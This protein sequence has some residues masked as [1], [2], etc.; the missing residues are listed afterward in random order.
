M[1]FKYNKFR[2]QKQALEG[3]DEQTKNNSILLAF[4]AEVNKGQKLFC[5]FPITEI[6]KVEQILKNNYHCYEWL[7]PNRQLKPFFDCEMEGEEFTI[8]ESAIRIRV[9]INFVCREMNTIFGSSIT[10]KDIIVLNS[11]RQGK[12]SYHLVINNHI[13]FANMEEHRIFIHWL[14]TKFLSPQEN[15]IEERQLLTWSRTTKGEIF[16]TLKI[17]DLAV[18]SNEQKIR[19]IN[20][21][22]MG[23]AYLLKNET[24]GDLKQSLIGLY[25]GVGDRQLLNV[26]GLEIEVSHKKTMNKNNKKTQTKTTA[27]NDS[28]TTTGKTIMIQRGLSYNELEK[29]ENYQQY[30]FLIP[31]TAQ[32][33]DFFMKMRF[34]IAQAGGKKEEFEEWARLSP[35]YNKNDQE[36]K[37][38]STIQ[39]EY[40]GL[41]F[42]KKYAKIS[43]PDFFNVE[44]RL[45]S[46]YHNPHF[47]D[48]E[49][50][51]ETSQF[52]SQEGTEF[53]KDI[54]HKHKIIIIKADLGSGKSTA[55]KRILPKYKSILII[56]PRIA[57]CKHAC[58]EFGV[59]SYLEGEYDVPYLACSLESFHR[60]PDSRD[61]ECVILDECEAILSLFSSSTLQGKQ[62]VVYNK[63]TRI[64]NNSKKTIFAGAFITQK[65]IDFVELF[66]TSVLLIRNDRV[67]IRKQAIQKDTNMFNID[68]IRYIKSGG[69]PYIYWN[70]RTQANIFIAELKG[71]SIDDEILAD[72]IDKMLFYSSGS[73]DSIFQ[74]LDNINETWDDASFVMATPSIT[75]GNSYS[76]KQTTFTSVWIASFPTCI[77]ADTIQGHKRV[78]HTTTGK[79]YYSLPD[80]K[81]LKFIS[82]SRGEI[83]ASIT[84]FDT[85][86][87]ERRGIVINHAIKQL[88]NNIITTQ[89]HIMQLLKG[90][91]QTI[92]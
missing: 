92:H 71:A 53:A 62:L 8:S 29:Y 44:H 38:D 14:N 30:L 59:A 18:Y 54:E 58:V 43:H 28:F 72:K 67:T 27:V 7:P 82:S 35:K 5:T 32:S 6:W 51:I 87:A 4:D 45:L 13:Y 77:V 74:G 26:S 24:L 91:V 64:I 83:I 81:L 56:T 15:E 40:N 39:P 49:T 89:K 50:I 84:G 66:N 90:W 79:L 76:P 48:I 70:S 63:I 3:L 2:S 52:V 60:I 42:L 75:V 21:S 19:C 55:I 25:K 23:K 46:D 34:M 73:D 57:Y 68:L 41:T 80:V 33:W 16:E 22:K 1:E 17:F 61:F 78:R 65:T 88:S 47:G 11:S 12:L 31:N 36:M 37:F 85:E 20:Q 69:K 9:F 86:T 10:E